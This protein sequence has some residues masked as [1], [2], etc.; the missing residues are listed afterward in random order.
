M[1]APSAA[2]T[3]ASFDVGPVKTAEEYLAEPAFA[4]ADLERGGALSLACIVCH[5]FR[6]G[7]AAL[8][9]PNLS[10]VFGRRAAT[11]EGFEYS[12]ALQ[13]TELIW[14]PRALD[15]WLANPSSFVPGTS[16]VF[17]G[18]SSAEDRRDLIAYLLRETQAPTE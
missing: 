5:A 2:P 9:G 16:M 12:Q 17:A 15:A 14:T 8:L 1:P 11:G 7:E 18:L 6:E 10:G 4:A 13:D 3:A